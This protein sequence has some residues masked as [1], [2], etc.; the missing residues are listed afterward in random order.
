[1]TVLNN[2]WE[3]TLFH[4]A[5]D[6]WQVMHPAQRQPA[7][8]AAL[9]EQAYA[10]CEAMT[11]EHSR[12]FYI[13]SGLLGPEQRRAVR[14]LYAFCRTTDDIVDDN[15]GQANPL[16]QTWRERALSW[17]PPRHDLV[18]LAWADARANYTIPQRYAEQLIDGVARD[19][20]QQRYETFEDLATYCYGV[21]STVGLMSMHIIGFEDDLA[22]PYAIKLGVALQMTNILRDVAEDWERGRLY[23]PL[24]EL[25]EY[26]LTEADIAAG[27]LDDRWRAFMRFQIE[28]T[29]E[30]YAEAWPGIGMLAKQG[31][32][33]IAAAAAFYRGILDDIEKHDYDVFSRRAHVSKWGKL[34]RLPGIWWGS[35]R[36]G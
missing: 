23:L 16:L 24:D 21:A 7:A 34:R 20:V 32:F 1:M 17:H 9:L 27:Q 36:T 22:V 35:R 33:S 14:A 15:P 28:R 3:H 26:G 31:R 6:A 10:H 25:G 5:Q 4:L 11:A 18:A 2:A 29:R 12:S 13:A 8:D 19:M 30:L